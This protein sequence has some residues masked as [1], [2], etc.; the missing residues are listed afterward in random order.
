MLCLTVWPLRT[1]HM[2]TTKKNGGEGTRKAEGVIRLQR[3]SQPFTFLALP[4]AAALLTRWNQLLPEF[5]TKVARGC[6][7]NGVNIAVVMVV[8]A[9]E[10][11]PGATDLNARKLDE[12]AE[13]AALERVPIEVRQAIQKARISKKM[14]Q[15]ELAKLI[16]EQPQNCMDSNCPYNNRSDR[17]W[18]S[19]TGMECSSAGVDF[20]AQYAWWCL[21]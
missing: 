5:W 9:M 10:S 15:A 7:I 18:S 8:A 14:S 21:E 2:Y 4:S 6:D 12:A 3:F 13:P 1:Q 16:N 20:A 11:K 19:V 17:V